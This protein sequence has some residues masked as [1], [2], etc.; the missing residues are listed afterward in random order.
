MWETP[1]I[2][3]FTPSTTKMEIFIV[4][5]TTTVIVIAIF[6]IPRQTH[7]FL[8]GFSGLCFMSVQ[9]TWESQGHFHLCSAQTEFAAFHHNAANCPVVRSCSAVKSVTWFPEW[10]ASDSSFTHPS[11]STPFSQLQSIPLTITPAQI[12]LNPFSLLPA[13]CNYLILRPE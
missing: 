12:L 6:G 11:L 2:I 4:V 3:T 8:R 9:S 5:I 13:S 10:W 1:K 7:S